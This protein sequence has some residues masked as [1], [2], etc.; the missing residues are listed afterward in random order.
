MNGLPPMQLAQANTVKPKNTELIPVSIW[1]SYTKL[2][3]IEHTI[4]RNAMETKNE[5]IV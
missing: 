3:K 2:I 4:V 5:Y 1:I